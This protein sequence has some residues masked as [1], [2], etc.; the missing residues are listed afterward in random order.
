MYIYI[1]IYCVNKCLMSSKELRLMFPSSFLISDVEGSCDRVPSNDLPCIHDETFP[2]IH[3][4]GPISD[5]LVI[6]Q[7]RLKPKQVLNTYT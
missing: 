3:F 7:P 6:I 5:C 1:Y 4:L 2:T